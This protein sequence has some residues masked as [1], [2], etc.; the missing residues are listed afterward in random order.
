M[1]MPVT[2]QRRRQRPDLG[3]IFGFHCEVV[4]MRTMLDLHKNYFD[5]NIK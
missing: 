3:R 4:F 1:C 2:G 5:V